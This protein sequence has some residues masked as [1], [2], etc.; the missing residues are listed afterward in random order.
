MVP[1]EA[2]AA[3]RFLFSKLQEQVRVHRGRIEVAEEQGVEVKMLLRK[4][5]HREG[6]EGYR[7]L[8]E[9]GL[10]KVEP[11]NRNLP[12]EPSRDKVKGVPPYPPFSRERLPLMDVVYPNYVSRGYGYKKKK[13]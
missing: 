9:P 6:L 11:D 4:F 1:G 13:Q 8:S 12:E 2:E 10:V 3:K 5:L 7:V